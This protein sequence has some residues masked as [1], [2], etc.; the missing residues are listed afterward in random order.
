MQYEDFVAAWT[1]EVRESGLPSVGCP[2]Q[3]IDPV[4]LDRRYRVSVEPI[5]GQYAGPLH[6]TAEL[7]WGWSAL[8]TARGISTEEDFLREVLDLQPREESARRRIRID[9]KLWASATPL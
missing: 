2:H 7:S 8:D 4:T 9:I 1:D 5:G 3:T 6:V